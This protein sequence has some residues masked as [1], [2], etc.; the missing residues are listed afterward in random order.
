MKIANQDVFFSPA[1]RLSC[2]KIVTIST[3]TLP[4]S[5]L[6]PWILWH[7][8]DDNALR[9]KDVSV[10]IYLMSVLWCT[11]AIFHLSLC[12]LLSNRMRRGPMWSTETPP[13]SAPS[14][15]TC[16]TASWSTTRS[17]PKKV[18]YFN[19]TQMVMGAGVCLL[20]GLVENTV[21]LPVMSFLF[22]TPW[23]LKGIVQQIQ[24]LS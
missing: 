5:R 14:S 20:C 6:D 18:S 9:A 17:W 4:S 1:S 13:T 16:G 8:F 15:T 12:F 7:E 23:A 19:S 24:P 21:C 22:E 10:I 2:L 11:D 3:W